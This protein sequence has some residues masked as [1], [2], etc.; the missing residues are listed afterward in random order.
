LAFVDL[1]YKLGGFKTEL[2]TPMFQEL[3]RMARYTT[4]EDVGEL[5]IAFLHQG[6]V[7]KLAECLED[8]TV[9]P[10]M[11]TKVRFFEKQN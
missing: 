7:T 11:V 10:G 9:L 1:R 4:G 5:P 3:G 6:T 8:H 2:L